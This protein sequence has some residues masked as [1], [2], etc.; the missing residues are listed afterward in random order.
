MNEYRICNKHPELRDQRYPGRFCLY[1][2]EEILRV[3]LR[4]GQLA[5]GEPSGARVIRYVAALYEGRQYAIRDAS[6]TEDGTLILILEGRTGRF[7]VRT[8]A[9]LQGFQE[10]SEVL[11]ELEYMLG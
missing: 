11:S 8:P 6:W 1:C 10:P 2:G 4:D 5:L 9:L 3:E 7:R